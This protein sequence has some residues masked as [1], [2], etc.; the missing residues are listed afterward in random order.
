MKL[1]SMLC[2]L[3][4][5]VAIMAAPVVGEVSAAPVLITP[6][7]IYMP[8][9]GKVV[10]EMNLSDDD[11]L[12]IIKQ[13]IPVVADVAKDI[14]PKQVAG[15]DVKAFAS[16]AGAIDFAGLSEAIAGIKSIRVLIAKYPAGVSAE[17]FLAE[18]T[19]GT[20][21]AGQFSKILTDFGTF[22]G[23]VGVYA[24]P[25][26]AGCMGFAYNPRQHVAYAARVVGGIDV[27]KLIK[28]AGG[29]AKLAVGAMTQPAVE[30][31]PAS[32]P[33]AAEPSVPPA[34][35]ESK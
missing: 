23:S 24:L 19:K 31:Q 8:A 11:V 2:A 32:S 4:G 13:A 27:P 30:G 5:L 29:V 15:G 28:W 22:P 12:G 17:R 16:V 20:A 34:A 3:L 9:G 35:V 33:N 7:V 25:N 21:K 10:T 18:F 6:P 26:N 1:I 14:A